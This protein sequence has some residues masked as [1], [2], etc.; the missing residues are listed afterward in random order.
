MQP[1]SFKDRV[2]KK[3]ITS[4]SPS[5]KAMPMATGNMRNKSHLRA[6]TT[7]KRCLIKKKSINEVVRSNE[8]QTAIRKNVCSSNS[9]L[10]FDFSCQVLSSNSLLKQNSG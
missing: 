1:F 8:L 9:G 10:L 7:R 3:G 6:Q 5:R 2:T 4:E